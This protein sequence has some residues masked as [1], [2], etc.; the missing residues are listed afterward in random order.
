MEA[1]SMAA[2]TEEK[3]K[4]IVHGAIDDLLEGPRLKAVI[5]DTISK[6]KIILR[7]EAGQERHEKELHRQGI[8]A[9]DTNAKVDTMLEILVATVKKSEKIEPLTN[10]LTDHELRLRAVEYTLQDHLKSKNPHR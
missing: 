7:L 6:N 5:D 2:V 8:L 3:V 1:F 10:S 4:Q 9:E